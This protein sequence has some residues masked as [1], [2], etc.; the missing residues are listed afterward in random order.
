MVGLRRVVAAV[1]IVLG[2]AQVAAAPSS[3]EPLVLPPPAPL[4]PAVQPYVKISAQRIALTHVGVI[5]GTGSAELTDRTILIEDGKIA[6]INASAAEVPAGVI[7]LDLSGHTVIPGI[8]GMHDHLYYIAR[9]NV[10][11]SGHGEPPLLVPQMTF[12]APRLYLANGVTTL[13]TT[14][15][16]ET[17]ADINLKHSIDAGDLPGPHMDVTGPYLEGAN[18]P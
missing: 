15:S 14:G 16:V 2:C 10:D 1:S 4:G 6:S 12:S 3:L 5:D 11:A 17:Y 8:V 7:T 13:R 9:P 18:S